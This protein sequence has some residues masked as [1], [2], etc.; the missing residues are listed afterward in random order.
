MAVWKPFRMTQ[1]GFRRSR[2]VVGV[3]TRPEPRVNHA[4]WLLPLVPRSLLLRPR[5]RAPCPRGLSVAPPP[6]VRMDR[7]SLGHVR[8]IPYFGSRPRVDPV[9]HVNNNTLVVHAQITRSTRNHARWTVWRARACSCTNASTVT[10]GTSACAWTRSCSAAAARTTW[11]RRSW[12]CYRT[13]R[14]RPCCS[15]SRAATA[16]R[17]GRS[18]GRS[19]GRTGRRRWWCG[20]TTWT[21]TAR[22]SRRR[23]TRSTITSRCRPRSR[24][25]PTCR[26]T[27]IACRPPTSYP[28]T[29]RI[30]CPGRPRSPT[31]RPPPRRPP[32]PS[33]PRWRRPPPP[34]PPP[35]IRPTRKWTT[36]TT[37]WIR[38]GLTGSY[39]YSD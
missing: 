6:P 19:T 8:L 29:G 13:R 5:S 18:T 15:R 31:P 26:R 20:R 7:Q 1:R 21:R 24:R 9:N 27:S 28:T 35:A 10:A 11:P 14:S 39:G 12:P 36:T 38:S 17:S 2:S 25:P 30:S 32:L 16:C 33:S 23:W 34:P 4:V 22:P 37:K 3:K